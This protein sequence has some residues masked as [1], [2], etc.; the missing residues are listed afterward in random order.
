MSTASRGSPRFDKTQ[1]GEDE[2]E[3]QEGF[4]GQSSDSSDEENGAS[5]A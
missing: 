1:V 5:M 3:H 2:D 4:D